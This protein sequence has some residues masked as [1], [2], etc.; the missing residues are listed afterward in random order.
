MNA[1]SN[2]KML[3]KPN[4]NEFPTYNHGNN[5]ASKLSSKINT[6][7]RQNN[8]NTNNTNSYMS[9]NRAYSRGKTYT[10]NINTNNYNS[11]TNRLPSLSG[12]INKTPSYITKKT[13][14]ITNNLDHHHTTNHNNNQNNPIS[15]KGL[16][17]YS[18]NYNDSNMYNSITK[19]QRK[20]SKN[21]ANTNIPNHNHNTNINISNY[22]S[23][24]RKGNLSYTTNLP[25]S[26]Y[27]NPS[28][29]YN[30][31]SS[32]DTGTGT[33]IENTGISNT[34]NNTS[35]FTSIP[36]S[37][38]KPITPNSQILNFEINT[39]N[40]DSKSS[41]L[42]SA[43][44]HLKQVGLVNLGNTCYINTGIQ[45]IIHSKHFITSF[46]DYLQ[47]NTSFYS[48]PITKEFY[49]LLNSVNSNPTSFNPRLFKSAIGMK[50]SK[51]A[52]GSQ[53][54][55]QEFLRIFLEILSTEC[56]RIRVKPK[57]KELDTKNKNKYQLNYDY[58]KLFTAREDSFV[59]DSSYGQ[60]INQFECS[61]CKNLTFSFEKFLDLPLL[62][63]N[64]DQDLNS[65]ISNHFSIEKIKFESKCE[66]CGEKC[67]HF[68]STR[69]S[70][71]PNVLIITLL[72]Y[73]TR[74]NSKITSRVKFIEEYN[75][76][77]FV[78]RELSGNANY[79]LYGVSNH[80]G[81]LNFGHYYAY[82]KLN[83]VWYEFNDS[84]VSRIGS[85]SF[86]NQNA[87]ALFYTKNE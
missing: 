48:K 80:T 55:S 51:Y 19:Y 69:I 65:I 16:Y 23:I 40:I 70:K 79:S 54:D 17:E 32:I 61:L 68:K 77:E 67:Y 66:K 42:L 33:G 10:N 59:V 86:N 22:P 73:N 49:N 72:R 38:T 60:L 56:N 62:L 27:S 7:I 41:N 36:S 3:S 8:T 5:M 39:A 1:F 63:N 44:L 78:D 85:F 18:N 57:Y 52:G 34:N 50:N 4:R 53:Q 29:S 31:I 9:T 28:S 11:N 21:F 2:I 71:T 87:Y 35:N 84:N 58:H 45:C 13:S 75:I 30:I 43:T 46:L 47:D 24:N 83:S 20:S 37:Y 14:S 76:S 6:N 26:N 64:K 12:N 25:S 74:S 82:I 81:S 15:S